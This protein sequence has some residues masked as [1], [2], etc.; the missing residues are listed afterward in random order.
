LPGVS[1]R[2]QAVPPGRWCRRGPRPG[3][4]DAV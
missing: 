2:G 4:H 1:G 3:H